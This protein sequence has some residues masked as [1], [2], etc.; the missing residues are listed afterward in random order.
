MTR[1]DQNDYLERVLKSLVLDVNRLA[2]R[3]HHL[4]SAHGPAIIK[5]KEEM[6]ALTANLQGFVSVDD[7]SERQ[8]RER[9]CYVR[10]SKNV[11]KKRWDSGPQLPDPL[12]LQA[13]EK[14][15]SLPDFS[16]ESVHVPF[17]STSRLRAKQRWRWVLLK[18]SMRHIR[19]RVPMSSSYILQRR[20]FATRLQELEIR[21]NH[22]ECRVRCILAQAGPDKFTRVNQMIF[23]LNRAINGDEG[24]NLENARG[25]LRRLAA[26]EEKMSNTHELATKANLRSEL[27][28]RHSES[29]KLE[30]RDAANQG[31][32]AY[33]AAMCAKN[34]LDESEISYKT[35]LPRARARASFMLR[36]LLDTCCN[37]IQSRHVAALPGGTSLIKNR[38][39]PLYH[40]LK[41]SEVTT[42]ETPVNMENWRNVA[43][44]IA[45]NLFLVLRQDKR[46]QDMNR[47]AHLDNMCTLL[48]VGVDL[49][50]DETNADILPLEHGSNLVVG[51]NNLLNAR[52]LVHACARQILKY[53]YFDC[54]NLG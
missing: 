41:T 35:R 33:K 50:I 49:H 8:R 46:L 37:A 18:L 36:C 9:E 4:E 29:L 7:L 52:Q 2:A 16:L 38:I 40:L 6:S 22:T 39:S 11:L 31:A 23:W 28:E 24:R 1:D 5:I 26:V 30:I 32:N 13:Y 12:E 42:K 10:H 54:F 14:K 17:E 19:R 44:S 51:V 48:D 20:S 27:T 45:R 43:R 25:I 3:V 34:K 47:R 15:S 53:T 21:T